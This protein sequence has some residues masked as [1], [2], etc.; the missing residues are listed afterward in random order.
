MW[1]GDLFM[2]M[3][4]KQRTK[5]IWKCWRCLVCGAYHPLVL[6]CGK[7]RLTF[8]D[9]VSLRIFYVILRVSF[10]SISVHEQNQHEIKNG[11]LYQTTTHGYIY[12]PN[13]VWKNLSCF[14]PDWK[15]LQKHF[16][17]IVIICSMIRVNKT[18]LVRDWIKND[19]KVWLTEPKENC[20]NCYHASKHY[21]SSMISP[22]IKN[23]N[24]LS[25]PF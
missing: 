24:Y 7:S 15:S 25:I 8:Q 19:G 11:R 6:Q 1:W 14:R 18:Y 12:W 2:K 5:L 22:L 17:Y 4:K 10:H 9:H 20:R 23:S 3:E 21:L 13:R 16:D